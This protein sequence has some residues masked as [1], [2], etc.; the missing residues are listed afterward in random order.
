V[1]Q[2]IRGGLSRRPRR[3]RRTAVAETAAQPGRPGEPG[4]TADAAGGG[5]DAAERRTPDGAATN[6]D[7]TIRRLQRLP[8]SGLRTTARRSASDE[9]RRSTPMSRP[10]VTS[11]LPPPLTQRSSVTV[12]KIGRQDDGRMSQ[13][14][15]HNKQSTTRTILLGS[16][17]YR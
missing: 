9:R 14:A 11:T 12:V 6:D 4:A 8:R 3:P 5:A 13:R 1:S 17:T 7:G 15:S 2:S 10:S 16:F